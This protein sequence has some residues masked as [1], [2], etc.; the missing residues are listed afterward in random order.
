MSELL[1]LKDIASELPIKDAYQDLIQPSVQAIGQTLSL[2]F[3]AVN[4]LL[5]PAMKWVM[6]GE[7]NL[8]CISQLV[9]EKVCGIP[10]EKLVEPDPYIAVPALQAIS[11][12]MGSDELRNMY[13]NLL[14]SSINVDEKDK[15]HPTYVEIIKQMSP[16]DARALEFIQLGGR[17]AVALCSIKWQEKSM[18]IWN[19]FEYIRD[20]HK[21]VYLYHN[22]V[23]AQEE[24]ASDHDIT[25]S[26]EN[27]DRLRL[28]RIWDDK[29]LDRERYRAFESSAAVQYFLA[30]YE[31]REDS[32]ENEIALSPGAA[33]IT[34]LGRAFSQVCLPIRS[35]S[36]SISL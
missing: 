16:L 3:R 15:V 20:E 26:F 28:I 33:E 4:V 29:V 7:E 21:G 22:L 17:S 19:D 12:S 8:K 27:L 9:S 13:A 14:A 24:G 31:S 34:T 2:P 11:Y 32:S 35:E 25:L 30:S 23:Q 6:R 1:P 18:P 5:T 36:V 10:E